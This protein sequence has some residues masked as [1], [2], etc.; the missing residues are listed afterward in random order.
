MSPGELLGNPLVLIIGGL[1]SLVLVVYMLQIVLLP[2]VRS[3]Q[4][5]AAKPPEERAAELMDRYLQ[6]E[7]E[8]DRQR[9]DP[10]M[11]APQLRMLRVGQTG[12]E[13]TCLFI[14][15][16]GIASNLEV[17]PVGDFHA[18]ISPDRVLAGGTGRIVIRGTRAPLSLLQFRIAYTDPY[19][20]R[21]SRVYAFSERE[22][23]FKEI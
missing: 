16:G 15:E 8:L 7:L 1:A 23:R 22:G 3:M 10:S 13:T 21:V 5:T 17:S 11:G 12:E 4:R 18:T 20:Q 2:F 6:N 9:R 14:N 19:A